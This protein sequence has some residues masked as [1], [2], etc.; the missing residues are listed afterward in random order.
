M[1]FAENAESY[2]LYRLRY[3]FHS[4][5]PGNLIG[6]VWHGITRYMKLWRKVEIFCTVSADKWADSGKTFWYREEGNDDRKILIFGIP[7]SWRSR[8]KDARRA[9]T[10]VH[11]YDVTYGTSD[12]Q[13]SKTA[14]A[15]RP[16]TTETKDVQ[17]ELHSHMLQSSWDAKEGKRK[18]QRSFR[19]EL[20]GELRHLTLWNTSSYK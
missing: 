14:A 16:R 12:L 4:L 15:W 17:G 5:W 18:R 7:R 1:D 19:I 10:A 20:S 2:F 8:E 13:Y 3:D 11:E 9:A 6:L